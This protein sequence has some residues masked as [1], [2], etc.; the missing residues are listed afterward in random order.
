M[1]FFHVLNI[2]LSSKLI[3]LSD[4][5]WIAIDDCIFTYN[6]ISRSEE[7]SSGFI[8][9]LLD[10]QELSFWKSTVLLTLFINTQSVIV[11]E[12]YNDESSL[13]IFWLVSIQSSF[14]SQLNLI[15]HPL[16]II[17]LRR[18][19][20]QSIHI[21]QWVFFISESIIRRNYDI[22]Y[23]WFIILDLSG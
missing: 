4:M 3:A 20:H 16:E 15:I 6:Q 2:P 18:L 14:E 23:I 10:F 17:L 8:L 21:S 12:E 11:E 22:Y 5:E 13:H 9:V 19:R 7:G 1:F